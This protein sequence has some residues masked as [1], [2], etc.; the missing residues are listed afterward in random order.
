MKTQL[1]KKL[2]LILAFFVLIALVACGGG[3]TADTDAPAEDN[4][5]QSEDTAAEPADSEE[6]R[7]FRIWHYEEAGSA[8]GDAWGRALEIFQETHPNVTVEFELKTFEQI[9][10]TAQMILNTD[11]AP[12][13]MEI[14]KGNATAGLYAKQG[15]LTDLTD[16][17][18]E[19]G[20]DE[21][22]GTSLQT[23]AR[24]DDQGI[25]G[26]GPL[27]GVTTY[28]EFVMV[29]YNKDMFAEYGLEVPTSL[30]EFEAIA[31]TF[32]AN[33]IVPLSL[34]ASS[35]W[36]VT[37][38]FYELVL[39]EGDQELVE[40]YQ[41]FKSD[42]DFHGDAFT[43][44]AE[45]FAE[46]VAAGY[47]GD[48]ANGVIQDDATAAFAQGNFP[49]ILTGSWM[50]GNF[51]NQITDFDWGIFLLPGKTFNTGSGGNLLVV[52]ENA[53]NKDLAYEFLDIT[54][55]EEVQ[56]LMANRG[57][58]PINAD[59]SQIE[60]EQNQELNAA[61]ATI[62]E[63]DGLAFYP[64]WPA[65]GYMDVLGGGLQELIAGSITPDAFLDQIAGPWQEY[66]DTLDE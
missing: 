63:N 49:M 35:V 36:P 38:N 65:P 52:P 56:T 26:G 8:S 37:Q 30:E 53:Q 2:P 4:A 66:K 64:D 55:S 48:N 32:V 18:A 6:E 39:Y 45:R 13:V 5:A 22:L 19:R 11:E 40:A 44:G 31:D 29:Y 51:Q 14:N 23:T 43:F 60:N 34:G 25:M 12:D 46:H 20:W 1:F 9:Q 3:E 41:L 16:V 54:L 7:V 42:L 58:I 62:V 61:F 50:F 57:G 24:Y 15:L 27:Y 28:G 10:Q 47:Y 33:D 17:A 59:L 21:L